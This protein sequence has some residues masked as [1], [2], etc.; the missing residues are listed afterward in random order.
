MCAGIEAGRRAERLAPSLNQYLVRLDVSGVGP[1]LGRGLK[2]RVKTHPA[3]SELGP[4][5][6]SRTKI[7][8]IKKSALPPVA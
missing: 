2:R 5:G 1:D 7:K 3:T 6:R 8:L 4:Y